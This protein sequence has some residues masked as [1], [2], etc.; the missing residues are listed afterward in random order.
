MG[1]Y[2]ALF[3]CAACG[4]FVGIGLALWLLKSKE[5]KQD[6][7]KDSS[8]IKQEKVANAHIVSE[9]ITPAQSTSDGICYDGKITAEEAKKGFR[10]KMKSQPKA[11]VQELNCVMADVDTETY[12]KEKQ[13]CEDASYHILAGGKGKGK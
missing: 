9:D 7:V 8:R 4:V 2:I 13:Q 6:F 5:G 11:S 10:N 12:L 1:F 3:M